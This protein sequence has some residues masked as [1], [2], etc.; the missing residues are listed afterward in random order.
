[1]KKIFL[2][3]IGVLIFNATAQAS[4]PINF[5]YIHG[6]NETQIEEFEKWTNEL[7]PEIKKNFEQNDT[8]KQVFLQNANIKNTPQMLY[9]GA[10]AEESKSIVD[11]GLDISDSISNFITRFTRSI[12]AYMLHD[13]IWLQKYENMKPILDDLHKQIMVN[14]KK[15]EKTVLVGYS[16]GTF[17]T[18]QYMANKYKALTIKDFAEKY[19]EKLN[20]NNA[21][22]KAISQYAPEKTCLDALIESN[23]AILNANGELTANRNRKEAWKNLKGLKKQTELSCAPDDAVPGIL[24]FGSPVIT[25]YSDIGKDGSQTQY[26]GFKTAWYIVENNKFFITVNYAKDPIG[27]P[28]ENHT[29]KMAQK[30]Y[31]AIKNGGGFIYNETLKGGKNVAAAHL[32]YIEKPKKFGKALSQVF[33]NGYDYFYEINTAK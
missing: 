30:R 6:A 14:Y 18:Y 24:N 5:L 1:M 9:W 3:L 21:D 16:A 11:K 28:F 13:A 31:P 25:F 10:R 12:L 19:K 32:T 23:V 7:H 27:M 22:I 20:L 4:T 26:F 2:L 15:G 17:I 29:F 8:V 33:T